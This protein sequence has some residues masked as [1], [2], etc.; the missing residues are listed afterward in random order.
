MYVFAHGCMYVRARACVF[1][2]SHETKARHT[3]NRQ[4]EWI[5]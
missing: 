1:M 5:I 2:I 3:D 4:T